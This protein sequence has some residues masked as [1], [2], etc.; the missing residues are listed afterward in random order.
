MLAQIR[1]KRH[2]KDGNHD[3]GGRTTPIPFRFRRFGGG[4]P[5]N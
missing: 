3:C 4:V 5:K 2:L 1:K